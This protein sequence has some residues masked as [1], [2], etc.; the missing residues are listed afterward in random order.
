MGVGKAVQRILKIEPGIALGQW[1][2]DRI[3]NNWQTILAVAGGGS[4]VTA[5]TAATTWLN[6]WGPIAW[7]GAFFV[8]AFLALALYG[9]KIRIDQKLIQNRFAERSLS[10]S[11]VS[12]LSDEFRSERVNIAEFYNPYYTFWKGKMFQKCQIWGPSSISSQSYI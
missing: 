3:T 11:F 4:V 1:M 8:G 2:Y 10:R 7:G 6:E 5:L 9:L 12:P